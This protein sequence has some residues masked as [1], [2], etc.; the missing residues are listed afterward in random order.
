M[1]RSSPTRC[2]SSKIRFVVV[3]QTRCSFGEATRNDLA[4]AWRQRDWRCSRPVSARAWRNTSRAK[5]AKSTCVSSPAITWRQRDRRSRRLGRVEAI[6]Q[7]AG[8]RVSIGQRWK[9]KDSFNETQETD[10]QMRLMRHATQSRY[11][12]GCFALSP[13][14]CGSAP[15]LRPS[16]SRRRS[17]ARSLRSKPP[18]DP[19][20]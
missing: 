9:V 1:H 3:L 15:P 7:I 12:L 2:N 14:V 11:T 8:L 10:E 6:E 5:C 16:R 13:V 4:I 19:R 17:P 20:P 18:A